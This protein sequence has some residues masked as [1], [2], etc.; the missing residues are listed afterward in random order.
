MHRGGG[1]RRHHEGD[2]RV[3][4][5]G[6]MIA[7]TTAL[8]SLAGCA[9]FSPDGGMLTVQAVSS[10]ALAK[11]VVRIRTDEE[12]RAAHER[13]RSLL[14]NS[15]DAD[16]AVQIAL[17]NNSGLQ[18]SFAELGAMEAQ[19]INAS[20]PPSPT[21]SLSRLVASRELEIER[22]VLVNV[23]GLL[24]LPRRRDLAQGRFR[25]AQFQAA[26]AVL[27]LAADTR[28]A[29]YR[30]VASGQIVAFLE[31]AK[32]AA[33]ASSE[34]A[35]KL[36]ETGALNKIGQARE[37]AFYAELGA[38]LAAA[39]LRKASDREKLTRLMGLWGQDI[40][41]RLLG[42]LK[43]LPAKPKTAGEIEAEAI[44]KRVDLEI[45][46]M[47]LDLLAKSYGLTRATRFVS[48]LELGGKAKFERVTTEE[49]QDQANWRGIDVEFQ[50]PLYDFGQSQTREAEERY[51]Q[52]AHRLAERAV[53]V[54]S[55]I[56]QAYTSY[57]GSFDIAM[58][59]QK[60]VL[61]L[62]KIISDET[63]LQYNGMLFDLSQ[64]LIDAR[65]RIT[66]N[67]A[68]IEAKRDFWLAVTDLH[69]AVVGGGV[70]DGA[71][72]SGQALG[73]ATAG[74]GAEH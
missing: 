18:A 38:Q 45:A 54:R 66:S 73:T 70:S 14:A 58:H 15:L 31:E 27:K 48:A 65:E 52:A 35:T 60:E 13:V 23:L 19:T 16:T 74:G 32:T 71:S 28:R 9:N 26:E 43:Q 42:K 1:R 20:L 5:R 67:V 53:N 8:T 10:D 6:A 29:Y 25:Q 47:E 51:M 2:K 24:T 62:R 63:L 36:G 22:Q 57:R 49:G 37:H 4:A 69:V 59:Y 11:D 61:P 39:R 12:A 41:Y 21:F 34:L 7:L 46:R 68:A 64:L 33:E 72:D 55:E 17:L 44:A 30:A 56:R 50:I 40:N 3:R